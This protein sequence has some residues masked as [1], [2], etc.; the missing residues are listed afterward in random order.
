MHGVGFGIALLSFLALSCLAA[1]DWRFYSEKGDE[2][3][4]SAEGRR[5]IANVLSW[6]TE[7]GGWPKNVDTASQPFVGDRHTL[8][9]TFDNG[10]T[11]G[12]L[13]FLAQAFRATKDARCQQAFERGFDHLLQAQYPSGGWPQHHPPGRQYHRHITFN[14][15]AMVRIMEF[16]REVTSTPGY[17]FVTEDRRRAAKA[18]FERGIEC[19]L[20]CQVVVN[21]KLT[22]WCAQHDE[23]S[24]QPRPGRTYELISLSGAESAGILKLLMSLDSPSPEVIRAVRA[25]A[26]WFES[27]R[28][29]GI[30]VVKVDGD[31]RVIEDAGAP[32]LWARFYELETNRPLFCGRDGVKKYRLAEIEAERRNGYAWYGDWGQPVA[33]AFA[34]WSAKW[35]PGTR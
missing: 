24:Y 3:Y 5:S 8:Q 27:V 19:I 33:R 26:E 2:W 15:S 17:A 35:C 16:I 29:R 9:A 32:R 31:K 12:E 22:A 7:G 28:I 34:Q 18:A 14:D 6:Q 25:G 30:R 20:R 11:T 21:G 13:R 4:R 10:A 23:L 1:P